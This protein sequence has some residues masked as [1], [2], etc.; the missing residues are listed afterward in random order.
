MEYDFETG[1][2]PRYIQKSVLIE[3]EEDCLHF[4]IYTL[5]KTDLNI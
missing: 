4:N 2:A 3:G 5:T 1:I